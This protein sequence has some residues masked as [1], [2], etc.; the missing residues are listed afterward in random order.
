MV[1]PVGH[2]ALDQVTTPDEMAEIMKVKWQ[3]GLDGGILVANPVPQAREIPADEI[4]TAIEAALAAADAEGVSGKD[5]T[6][7]CA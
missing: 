6:P 2:S 1:T 5:V 3:A 7:F 4:A